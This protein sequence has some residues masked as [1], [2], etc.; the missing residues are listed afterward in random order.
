MSHHLLTCDE[1]CI[2]VVVVVLEAYGMESAAV[3]E[4]G[5][6]AMGNLAADSA[7]NTALESAGACECES[8]RVGLCSRVVSFCHDYF[9]Y[10]ST[11]LLA[12][13]SSS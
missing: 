12:S 6:R 8:G 4:E 3:A 5:C 1:Y 2:A 10:H 11:R 7:N 9:E 13:V